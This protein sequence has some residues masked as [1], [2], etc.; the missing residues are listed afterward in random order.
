M[1]TAAD[2]PNHAASQVRKAGKSPHTKAAEERE[3]ERQVELAEDYLSAFFVHSRSEETDLRS[4]IDP[5]DVV[6]LARLL[7]ANGFRSP[8][9]A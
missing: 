3:F 8:K 5:F 2:D 6:R 9:G 7:V 1:S 4:A